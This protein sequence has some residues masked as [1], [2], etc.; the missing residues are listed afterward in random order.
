MPTSIAAVNRFFYHC[1]SSTFSPPFTWP[2]TAV[3][4]RHACNVASYKFGWQ[5]ET[6]LRASCKIR[7]CLAL[8]EFPTTARRRAPRDFH[9]HSLTE[10][11]H[12][13]AHWSYLTI[14]FL[15]FF[16][17]NLKPCTLCT[18][19]TVVS[20]KCCFSHGTRCHFIWQTLYE[21][22]QSVWWWYIVEIHI[23]K[24]ADSLDISCFFLMRFSP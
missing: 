14:C 20:V 6:S 10:Q 12:A 11:S 24:L 18:V 16:Y 17:Y 15:F 3:I 23:K 2:Y 1:S 8:I 5:L 19:Y 4:H 7:I 21:R 13:T 9:T 22:Y